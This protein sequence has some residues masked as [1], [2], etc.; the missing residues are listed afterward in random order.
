MHNQQ[1]CLLV[2]ES[3]EAAH[4]SVGD[5]NVVAACLGALA[6]TKAPQLRLEEAHLISGRAC[7]NVNYFNTYISA[8]VSHLEDALL[9]VYGPTQIVAM[10]K[11]GFASF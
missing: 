5:R 6:F 8:F 9:G 1:L 11:N 3:S 4:L 7:A 10:I 2:R